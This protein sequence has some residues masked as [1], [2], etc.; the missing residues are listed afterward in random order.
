MTSCDYCENQEPECLIWSCATCDAQVCADHYGTTDDR[1]PLCSPPK[2][3]PHQQRGCYKPPVTGVLHY[4]EPHD[5]TW[6]CFSD[7]FE[8]GSVEMTAQAE[9]VSE[10]D[11]YVAIGWRPCAGCSRVVEQ[12]RALLSTT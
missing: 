2:S 6:G 1:L 7:E 3:G 9:C 5:D 4:A 11:E 8:L 12:R 10:W